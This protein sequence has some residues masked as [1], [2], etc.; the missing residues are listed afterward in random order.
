M[1]TKVAAVFA[2]DRL[3][4]VFLALSFIIFIKCGLV[5]TALAMAH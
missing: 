3:R 4:T 1:K 5:L 2:F